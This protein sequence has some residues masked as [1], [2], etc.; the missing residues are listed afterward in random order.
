MEPLVVSNRLVIPADELE[1]DTAR[2]GGPGGQKVNKTE[3][4]VQ[5]RFA[6]KESRVL[7]EGQRRLILERL[8]SRMTRG[9]E[10]LVDCSVHRSQ[11]ANLQAAR[12]RLAGLL[13]D[14][15]APRK[16][17]RAT[18]PTR[19]SVRRRLEGKRRRS[20]LKRERGKRHE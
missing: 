11:Q 6:V 17:R 18:K 14:A 10:L 13:S 4:R 7:S 20:D 9:G 1:F 12:E 2:A 15:L 8:G 3:T 16:K 19:S 5:L